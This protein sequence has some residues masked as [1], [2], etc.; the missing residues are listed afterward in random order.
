MKSNLLAQKVLCLARITGELLKRAQVGREKQAAAKQAIDT[1]LPAA[2]NAVVSNERIFEHQRDE[3]GTKLASDHAACLEF[4]RDLAAHRNAA[5]TGQI[6][7]PAID[8]QTKKAHATALTGG[9]GMVDFDKME[10]GQKF[11]EML[12]GDR[13]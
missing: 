1:A 4:I 8:G 13:A 6:G 12:M 5:E 2:L 11:T 3:V 7:T 10:S 9:S